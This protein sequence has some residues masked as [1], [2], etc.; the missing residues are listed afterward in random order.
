MIIPSDFHILRGSIPPRSL[1]FGIL[2][3]QRT[4]H[5]CLS[6]ANILYTV[7]INRAMGIV[8]PR[9]ENINN[10]LTLETLNEHTHISMKLYI[11][12]FILG[13]YSPHFHIAAIENCTKLSSVQI[14][15]LDRPWNMLEIIT[16]P[17]LG[18]SFLNLTNQDNIYIEWRRI[19]NTAQLIPTLFSSRSTFVPDSDSYSQHFAGPFS[20]VHSGDHQ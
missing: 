18:I 4:G 17:E 6:V 20:A 12:V 19:L 1:F 15:L 11:G 8:K 9:Q 3:V 2:L 13:T 7:Y 10:D 16:I 5:V 14:L